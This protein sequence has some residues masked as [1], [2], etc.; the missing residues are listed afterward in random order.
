MKFKYPQKYAVTGLSIKQ[1]ISSELVAIT[2]VDK[3]NN[4]SNSIQKLVKE[5]KNSI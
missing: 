1:E 4:L 2:D 3:L 5:K